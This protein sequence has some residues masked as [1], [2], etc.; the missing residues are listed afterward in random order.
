MYRYNLKNLNAKLKTKI[1]R[2]FSKTKNRTLIY[3]QN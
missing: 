2:K 3:S 1:Y